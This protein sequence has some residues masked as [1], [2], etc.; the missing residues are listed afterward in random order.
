MSSSQPS[1]L[2]HATRELASFA[3]ITGFADIPTEVIERIKLSLIDG[4]G[5]CLHGATLPW[6]Q[7]VC[8]LAREEGGNPLAS[9]WGSGHRTSTTNA[10]LVNSTAGHAFEMDDIHKES[11]LHPNSLAVPIAL[12]LAEADPTVTGRDIAT[13]LAVGYEVGLRVGN[14]ATMS[15]FLNG[16]HPQGTSGTFVAAATAGKMLRLN[17]EQMQN[18]LGIAGS[19]AAGLMASQEGAMVKRLH[20]G[21][22]AQGGLLAALLAKR[23]FTGI[24]DVV[25]AGYGGFLSS[26]SR[27]PNPSRLLEGIGEDWEAGKVG[28]KMYPNVTSI[29]AA[30][31]AMRSILTEEKL[32]AAD[33]AEVHVGCGHMTFVH[34]AWPY[35]PAGVTAAQMN[36]YYGLSVMAHKKDVTAADYGEADIASPQLLDFMSKIKIEEDAELE[37]SGPS[38]RHAARVRVRTID[39]R[40][41]ARE[42]LHRRGSPENPVKWGDIERKFNANIA[43]LLAPNLGRIL[44]DSCG[45]LEKLA[46]VTAINDILAA[47]FPVTTAPVSKQPA[48]A[49]R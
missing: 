43:G 8:E 23:S 5:V 35:R 2:P 39:G 32:E 41:F 45:T 18:A 29:H 31:D 46:N 7:K 40:S 28:F 26:F 19:M 15:L 22:A 25:E 38:L 3:A 49:R 48:E 6:T 4:L 47:T 42:I 30:L 17:A 37:A 33:I 44:L 11:I 16:F 21:R 27:T 10:V 12:A 9:I 13:A 20:T 24:S 36:M 1:L 14:T 34:T